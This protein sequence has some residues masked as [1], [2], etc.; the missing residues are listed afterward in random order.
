MQTTSR[1]LGRVDPNFSKKTI[2]KKDRGYNDLAIRRGL[3]MLY[4]IVILTKKMFEQYRRR[5]RHYCTVASLYLWSIAAGTIKRIK[6]YTPEKKE[7]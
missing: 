1:Q 4:L 5:Y 7:E 3:C 2:F 6:D